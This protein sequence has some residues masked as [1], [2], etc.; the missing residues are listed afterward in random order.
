M[1]IEAGCERF[2]QA[3]EKLEKKLYL[4]ALLQTG[5]R[6]A[7]SEILMEAFVSCYRDDSGQGDAKAMEMDAF[8][9]AFELS[10]SARYTLADRADDILPDRCLAGLPPFERAAVILTFFCRF[11]ARDA[12]DILG[13]STGRIRDSGLRWIGFLCSR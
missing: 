11:T 1:S 12:A 5:S 4:F 2:I 9:V 7:A 8:R 10:G 3:G 6:M 13:V